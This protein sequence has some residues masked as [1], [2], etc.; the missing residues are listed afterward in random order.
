MIKHNTKLDPSKLLGFISS[1]KVGGKP[2]GKPV[3]PLQAKIGS[4][5]GI[6]N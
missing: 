5:A 1:A 6:K 2:T 3:T 4:K